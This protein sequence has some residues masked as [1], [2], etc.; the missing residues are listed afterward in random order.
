M[1]V[2]ARLAEGGF[3]GVPHPWGHQCVLACRS[4]GRS[5]L[6]GWG[7]RP[8]H[9]CG[10]RQCVVCRPRRLLMAVRCSGAWKVILGLAVPGRARDMR[11]QVGFG[12]ARMCVGLRVCLLLRPWFLPMPSSC[13]TL[14]ACSFCFVCLFSSF[15][16][17]G[18]WLGCGVFG[19]GSGC[20]CVRVPVLV[21]AWVSWGMGVGWLLRSGFPVCV[22]VP[23]LPVSGVLVRGA[24][25]AG[26]WQQWC[27]GAC[28]GGRG[29]WVVPAWRGGARACVWVCSW[30]GPVG[31]WAVWAWL[32]CG[33]GWIRQGGC[34]VCVR[35]RRGGLGW[36]TVG[37]AMGGEDVG[38][39]YGGGA[40]G[41]ETGWCC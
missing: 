7:L 10:R 8:C 21:W 5:G 11:D 2:S 27:R 32:V 20:G 22:S 18:G 15:F 41:A 13:P 31:C 40:V 30:R 16:W 25:T 37:D 38:V 28:A 3:W 19:A 33:C 6:W 34:R 35:R 39:A 9:P 36:G 24:L 14:F 23:M 29:S 4:G 17:G 26:G 12:G 1:V